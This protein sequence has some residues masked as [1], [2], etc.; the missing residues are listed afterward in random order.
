M[1]V[2]VGR[3]FPLYAGSSGTC[4]LAFLPRDVQAELLSGPLERLTS[5]TVVEP[6]LLDRELERIRSTGLAMSDGQRQQGA[7][8]VA[9][10]VFGLDGHVEG[11]I[12]VCGPLDRLD[13]AT[14]ERFAPL[15]TVA[16]DQI[17]RALGWRGGLPGD[18]APERVAR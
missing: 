1:T 4:I 5:T 3:R 18:P 17:S 7:G 10:P 14:R 13:R 2:E 8:S 15:L 6:R 12:S 11:S 9:A 16:A